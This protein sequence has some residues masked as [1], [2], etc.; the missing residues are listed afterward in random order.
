VVVVGRLGERITDELGSECPKISACADCVASTRDEHAGCWCVASSVLVARDTR[1]RPAPMHCRRRNRSAVASPATDIVKACLV[2]RHPP[3]LAGRPSTPGARGN[4][5]GR[6]EQRAD[7][8][9]DVVR[10]ENNNWP[11]I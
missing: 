9:A 3:L 2:C 1:R 7:L 8:A 11:S 4:K 10:N 6:S 5:H